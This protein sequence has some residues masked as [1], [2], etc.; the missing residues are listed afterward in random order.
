M[1]HTL[2]NVGAVTF[3]S[4]QPIM[5][6]SADNG[7]NPTWNESV[8]FDVSCPQLAFLRFVVQDEDVFGDPNFMGQETYHVSVPSLNYLPSHHPDVF[9]A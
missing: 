4:Y 5:S 9:N 6:C 1:Y 3:L 2:F 8:E 7:F